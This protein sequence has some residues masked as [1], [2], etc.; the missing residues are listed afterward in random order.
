MARERVLCASAEH[1]TAWV[2][3]GR[4]LRI[5]AEFGADEADFAG[6]AAYLAQRP[7]CEFTILAD[8]ADEEF[9]LQEI[10]A[11]RGR[12][13]RA[14]V[15]RKLEQIH[16]GSPLRIAVACGRRHGGRRDERVLFAAL[17]QAPALARWLRLLER[18]DAAVAGVASMAQLAERLPSLRAHATPHRLVVTTTRA[19]LRQT[20]VENGRLRLSR[21]TP[22]VTAAELPSACAAEAERLRQYLAGRVLADDATLPVTILAEPRQ[23]ERFRAA[24]A[25]TARLRFEHIDLCVECTRAGAREVP[26]AADTEALFVHL[27][28]RQRPAEQF[29]P[30]SVRRGFVLRRAERILHR[31]AAATLAAGLLTGGLHW[32]EA[33]QLRE[34][35][36]ARVALIAADTRRYEDRLRALPPLPLPA[37]RLRAVL[38]GYDELLR[39]SP[40][41]AA[42]YRLLGDALVEFP[43][44]FIERLDW[45]L[46]DGVELELNGSLPAAVAGDR[47]GQLDTVENLKQRLEAA[48]AVGV[49]IVTPPFDTDPGRPLASNSMAALRAKFSL[50]IALPAS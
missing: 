10:P 11:V 2:R 26:H 50:R 37:E 29:A 28:M 4:A 18:A 21:L 16:F 27:L 39:R 7:N 14:L 43:Q 6:F 24:C 3:E 5:E 30:P 45:K 47:R 38:D 12:D 36:A 44:V 25:D 9:E 1:L 23:L 13:R 19:G 8:L 33:R 22:A 20:L 32:F 48:P 15:T 17:P 41:P 40:Q 31:A 49:R 46:G 42:A 35:G 34:A